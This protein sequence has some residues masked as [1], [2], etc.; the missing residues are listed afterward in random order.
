MVVYCLQIWP[1][2]TLTSEGYTNSTLISPFA[3]PI[4]RP[5]AGLKVQRGAL[6]PLF[7]KEDS[8]RNK[9]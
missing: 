9:K 1:A 3:T 2:E 4:S 6:K 5:H 8:V 7:D